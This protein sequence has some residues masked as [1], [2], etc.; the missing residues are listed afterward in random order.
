MIS[1]VPRA[2]NIFKLTN[3][4]PCASSRLYIEPVFNFGGL[5]YGRSKVR[6]ADYSRSAEADYTYSGLLNGSDR[7]FLFPSS[8]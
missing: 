6:E 8:V 3:D 7:C 1:S 5:L 2:S 4:Q